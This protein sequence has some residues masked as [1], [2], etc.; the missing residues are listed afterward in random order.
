MLKAETAKDPTRTQVDASLAEAQRRHASDP[1]RAELIAR[2]R[3]FKSSWIELAEAL[4]DCRQQERFRKWGYKSFPDF[5]QREL[6]LKEST[7]DKLTGS[8]AFLRKSAPEVLERDGVNDNIPSWQSID[9]L[10]R[11]EEA[12][13]NGKASQET[14]DE[15]RRAVVDDNMPLPKVTRLFRETLFPSETGAEDR[16]RVKEAGKAARRLSDLIGSLRETNVVPDAVISQVEQALSA[17]L[18]ALP[19]DKEEPAEAAA[20]AA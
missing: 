10:R 7:V 3:R 2:T 16:K 9:F 15:V 12:A 19:A 13:Q 6:H 18:R 4:T 5:Y 20:A 14:V 17:L 1:Q 11:A 8:F